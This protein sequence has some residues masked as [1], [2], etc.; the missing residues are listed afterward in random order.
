MRISFT[1]SLAILASFYL[2]GC[3]P[4]GAEQYTDFDLVYTNYS[5]DSSFA[6]RKTFAL[7]DSIVMITGDVLADPSVPPTMMND[8]Y[9]T[10]I[11]A[12]LKQNMMTYGWTEVDKNAS[13]DVILL[14]S[15]TTTTN[16]YYYYDWGYWGWYYP[17]YYPGWGWYY[18]GY[19][20]PYVTSFRTGSLFVQMVDQQAMTTPHEGNVP[21]LWY[22]IINGLIE[23]GTTAVLSRVQANINQAFIQSPYLKH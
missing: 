4:K 15:G 10:P 9:A 8:I 21:I 7:P 14:V 2:G 11:L 16:L 5:S 17:G 22:C 3:Y 6:D 18:P 12:Q 20:P 23:G 1:F 13:P 19:Y